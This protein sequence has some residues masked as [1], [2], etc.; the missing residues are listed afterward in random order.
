MLPGRDSQHPDCSV[1]AVDKAAEVVLEENRFRRGIEQETEFLFTVPQGLFGLLKFADVMYQDKRSRV[2]SPASLQGS[3]ADLCDQAGGAGPGTKFVH[4]PSARQYRGEEPGAFRED[5]FT[6]TADSHVRRLGKERHSGTVIINQK[7]VMI[8]G[9]HGITQIFHQQAP[10][11]RRQ[12]E[13]AEAEQ[14]EGIENSGGGKGK[15]NRIDPPGEDP[16]Q[17][18]D[19][20][21]PGEK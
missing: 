16:G 17:M 2:S 6:G 12:V 3:N 21:A 10:R 11:H 15:G 4:Q 18:P 9:E 19:K 13:Q 14:A 7:P 1:V 8:E 20:S 5:T